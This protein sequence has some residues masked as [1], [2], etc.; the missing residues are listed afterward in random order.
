M[1]KITGYVDFLSD[2]DHFDNAT[3]DSFT[4]GQRAFWLDYFKMMD[5]SPIRF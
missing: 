5:V 4:A 1:H 2:T 3:Q